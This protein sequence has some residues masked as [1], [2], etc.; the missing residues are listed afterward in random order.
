MK[1]YTYLV[2][3][4]EMHNNCVEIDEIF[5]A[6]GQPITVINSGT[7]KKDHW[8]NV[9]DIRYYRQF[10]Y[11]LKHFDMSYDY[12]AFLCGDVSY[13]EWS[14]AIDR[15]KHVLSVYNNTALYAP[16]F[17][18]EP[19][20]EPSSK[21][22]DVEH[23]DKL[24]I[25]IQTDGI[26]VFI[27]RDIV[28]IM[29]DYFN[30]LD[31]KIDLK[32]IKS[33]WGLD[34]I[35]SSLAIAMNRPILRDKRFVLSHPAG[36]SYDHSAATREMNLLFEEFYNYLGNIGLDRSLY[37][38]LHNKIYGRMSNLDGC[39]E[40][41]DFYNE[42]NLFKNNI[43]YHIIHINDERKPNRDKIQSIINGNIHKIYSLNAKDEAEMSKF[44]SS[45]PDFKLGWEGFKLGE[46]GN[47]G[48]HYA[49]WNYVIDNDLDSLLVF[50]DDS[51]VHKDFI[52]KY[53]LITSNTPSDYDAVSVYVDP[54]QFDRYNANDY[55]NE[56]VAKGY[57]DWSTLCY[58]VS[59]QGAKKL[60]EYVNNN[61]MD[62][63][64]DWFIFRNGH[65][66]LFN[67]YTVVPEFQSP[68][69]IDK[70]YESQ[71]Q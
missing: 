56:Y 37:G 62:Y 50:E 33:G 42:F 21:I 48:S 20:S 63:P 24:N 65:K 64:T 38:S 19:W 36:S 7:I 61:G 22:G 14:N 51:I 10:Y 6:N 44:K 69:E 13:T 40:I 31:S 67:V 41:S 2:A 57:Q 18:H 35:W 29:L 28:K 5:M 16:H 30:Y 59:R 15:A 46:I 45:Y 9:G 3:W 8:H 12:M 4:D 71:V 49:A 54:N 52:Y 55:V 34:L 11:A 60:V 1:F 17:T 32:S 70:Q 26:Y 66:G 43:D 47:F 39:R 68:L 25:A 23:D 27:H 58:I 53:N